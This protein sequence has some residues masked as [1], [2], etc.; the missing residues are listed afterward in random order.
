MR[1]VLLAFS[2]MLPPALAAQSPARPAPRDGIMSAFESVVDRYGSNLVAAFD[3]I[4]STQYGFRPRPVQ[5]SVGYIAQH[6]EAA[7]Y[8][9]C[10]QVGGL[11]HQ[12]TARDSLAD[13]V[14]ARWPKDTLVARL[15][16]SL[17]FCDSALARMATLENGGQARTL[18]NLETDLAEHYSQVSGYMRQL[19][20]VPPTAL[21]P[22]PRSAIALSASALAPYTGTYELDEARQLE[23]TIRD[24]ALFGGS[25]GGRTLRLWPET[26]RDFFFREVDATLTFVRDPGGAVTGLVVHQFGRDRFAGKLR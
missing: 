7:N 19:G 22:R 14:K 24:G 20:L 15:R 17:R 10:S 21:P 2:L 16:A 23:V 18:L 12:M 25:T 4:P 6:L 5:Q 8:S 9:Q 11:S 3:S 26:P 13:T 1:R